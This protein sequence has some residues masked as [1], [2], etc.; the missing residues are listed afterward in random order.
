MCPV[1]SVSYSSPEVRGV[2]KSKSKSEE[3]T[4]RRNEGVGEIE[5]GAVAFIVFWRDA[6]CLD[7]ALPWARGLARLQ[8]GQSG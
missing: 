6:A 1:D 3:D 7:F 2:N 5:R 8:V 4:S